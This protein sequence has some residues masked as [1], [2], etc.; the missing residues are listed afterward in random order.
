M[1]RG[2]DGIFKVF[3]QDKLEIIK[4]TFLKKKFNKKIKKMILMNF[5]KV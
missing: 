4:Y 5:L 2:K 3:P 1:I